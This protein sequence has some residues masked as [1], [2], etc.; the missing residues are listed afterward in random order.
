[1]ELVLECRRGMSSTITG[2][3]R[4]WVQ[5]QG[6]CSCGDGNWSLFGMGRSQ[7]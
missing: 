5:R 4:R 2:E 7:R 6:G 1:M 3:R